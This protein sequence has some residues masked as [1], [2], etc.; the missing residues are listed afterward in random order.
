MKSI[1]F[2]ILLA[3]IAGAVLPVQAGLNAKMGKAVG[4][5]VYAALISFVIGSVG[6]F[7]Y[8]SRADLQEDP[9]ILRLSIYVM[10]G[11]AA[12][13]PAAMKYVP[14]TLPRPRK[15]TPK[16]V[17]PRPRKAMSQDVPNYGG[18][19]PSSHYQK[20]MVRQSSLPEQ[21]PDEE[22]DENLNLEDDFSSSS[23][24]EYDPFK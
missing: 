20:P 11:L 3:A 13:T 5:P 6:L 1:A 22:G 12:M 14:A 23:E 16:P 8:E 7:L 15:D 18:Q 19:T 9:G 24:E 21:D 17:P 10:L 4:D 2:F